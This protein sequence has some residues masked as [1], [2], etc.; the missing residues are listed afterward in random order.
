[1]VYS[2]WGLRNTRRRVRTRPA[3]MTSSGPAN[4]LSDAQN[5][6]CPISDD[7]SRIPSD[8]SANAPVKGTGCSGDCYVP[9]HGAKARFEMRWLVGDFDDSELLSVV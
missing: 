4:S 8:A 6:L 1:M 9:V 2:L 5:D 3:G 7:R